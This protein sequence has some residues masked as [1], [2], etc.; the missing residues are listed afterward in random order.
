MAGKNPQGQNAS[1]VIMMFLIFFSTFM[2]ISLFIGLLF[3]IEDEA[4]IEEG[5]NKTGEHNLSTIGQIEAEF[6]VE[7]LS[8]ESGLENTTQVIVINKTVEVTPERAETSILAIILI[9]A[10]MLLVAVYISKDSKKK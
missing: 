1:G 5:L 2:L 10:F 3:P 9:A 4:L 6:G 7:N 8:S